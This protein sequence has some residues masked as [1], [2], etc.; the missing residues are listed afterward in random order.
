MIFCNG[1]LVISPYQLT[2]TGTQLNLNFASGNPL[3]DDDVPEYDESDF[4]E[5]E[6]DESDED[7]D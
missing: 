2:T 4:D 6:D 7:I 1:N 3:E 5:S